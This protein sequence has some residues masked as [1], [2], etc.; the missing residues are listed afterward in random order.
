MTMHLYTVRERVF[1][2]TCVTLIWDPYPFWIPKQ[3]SWNRNLTS[4]HI[5][6]TQRW[7]FGGASANSFPNG[8]Y[9]TQSHIIHY[10]ISAPNNW[11][12]FILI[13]VEKDKNVVLIIFFSLLGFLKWIPEA[14]NTG[15]TLQ[16]SLCIYSIFSRGG[17]F[18]PLSPLPSRSL[19]QQTTLLNPPLESVFLSRPL[20]TFISLLIRSIAR[21]KHKTAQHHHWAGTR[22]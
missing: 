1:V 17:S 4:S 11:M 13:S 20:S 5:L 19:N 15:L 18:Y 22:Q 14:N 2:T 6:T 9:F 8:I 21:F 10:V 12:L 7:A 16:L 3:V